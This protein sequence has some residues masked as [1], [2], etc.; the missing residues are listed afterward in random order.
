MRPIILTVL[1]AALSTLGPVAAGAAEAIEPATLVS[2][3]RVIYSQPTSFT[4]AAM[5]FPLRED[6]RG[7]LARA[8]QNRASLEERA[9]SA[10]LAEQANDAAAEEEWTG[11]LAGAEAALK[12]SPQDLRL[13]ELTVEAMVG[14]DAAVR[15]VPAAAKLEA[16]LPG[17]WRTHLLV[18]DAYFRRADH[19]WR[20]LIQLARGAAG[21]PPE[22]VQELKTDL[23]A[24]EKAYIRAATLAPT[25]ASPRAG[26][27]ALQLARPVMS[28][29]LP[30]GVLE[31]PAAPD[32]AAVRRELVDLVRATT[33]RVEPLWHATHFLATQPTEEAL[34]VEERRVL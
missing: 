3:L 15:A 29:M 32:V 21:L 30:K 34:S 6:V 14:A 22:R 27:I 13:L 10:R 18:G 12:K 23:K 5:R 28:A 19:N 7:D 2:R 31:S 8:R 16:A 1:G 24:A 9:Q 11:V 26:K 20:V 33:G 25:E 17:A 4:P